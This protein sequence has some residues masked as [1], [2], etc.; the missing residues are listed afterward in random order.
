MSAGLN[1][2][3]IDQQ[4]HYFHKTSEYITWIIRDIAVKKVRLS[5]DFH[6]NKMYSYLMRKILFF[7]KTIKDVQ[8]YRVVV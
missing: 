2:K 7:M 4:N 6:R 3:K 5:R 8:F 1:D